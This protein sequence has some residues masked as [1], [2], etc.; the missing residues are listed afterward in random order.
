MPL[1]LLN[2]SIFRIIVILCVSKSRIIIFRL[3]ITSYEIES[4]PNS[5][6]F[7]FSFLKIFGCPIS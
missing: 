5:F 2:L 7:L 1:N 6:V 4:N 3:Y